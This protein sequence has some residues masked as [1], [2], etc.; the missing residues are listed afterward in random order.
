MTTQT[1]RSESAEQIGFVQWFEGAFAGVRILH[2]PNGGHRAMSVARKLKAEGVKAGVP[3]LFI[4]VWRIWI[5]MKRAKGG[6]LLADQK[7]WIEYL[8]GVGYTVIVAHGAR[9]ASLKLLDVLRERK[10][11]RGSQAE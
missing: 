10:A 5:E 1:S 3:D 9:D 2:V 7:D 8:Q 4:P 6:R 11:Q